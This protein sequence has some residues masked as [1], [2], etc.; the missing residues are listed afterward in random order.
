[1]GRFTLAPIVDHDVVQASAVP[2]D[3]I[4]KVA[5][6]GLGQT[7]PGPTPEDPVS[8]QSLQ[9]RDALAAERHPR[10]GRRFV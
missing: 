10:R 9:P 7:P 8:Y 6:L 5:Q 4:L 2:H 3:R 1:M